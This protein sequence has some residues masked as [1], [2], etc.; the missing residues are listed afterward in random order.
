M[1]NLKKILA[2]VLALVMSLS[3]MATASAASFPDVADDN[4]YKT[5]IDVLNGVKVFQGYNDGAEFRPTGEITRAEVAAIIYRISTGDVTDSQKDIY[6]AWNGA[7]KL[8]DVTTGWYAGYVNFC[9]NAG[10][11]KGYPDGTFKASNK[12]TGYEVLAMILRAVGYGRNGEFSGSNWAITVGSLAQTLGITKN[13]KEDLGSPATRQMV[14]ELLFRSI[15]TETQKYNALYMYEGTGTNLAANLGLE[16]ITGVVTA[17][18]IADLDDTTPLDAGKTRLEAD[19][20]KIYTLNVA[21]TATDIGETRH[22]YVKDGTEVLTTLA[23]TGTN[24]INDNPGQ[25]TTLSKVIKDMGVRLTDETEYYINFGDSEQYTCERR[26]EY[27]VTFD[28]TKELKGTSL[29]AQEWFEAE[30]GV[31]LDKILDDENTLDEVDKT[32]STKVTYTRVIPAE[33]NITE[34]DLAVMR[35][36]FSVADDTAGASLGITGYV[37]AGTNSTNAVERNKDLSEDLSWRTFYNDYINTAAYNI[38][39]SDNGEWFKVIDNNSDGKADYVLLTRF[40][41]TTITDYNSRTGY[42]TT[43]WTSEADEDASDRNTKF[44]DIHKDDIVSDGELSID[45]VILYAKIDG[46][47]YVDAPE[48]V[49]TSIKKFIYK[50]DTITCAD[51]QDRVWSGINREA[52][53]FFEEITDTEMETGR[54]YTMFLD[55]FGYVRLVTDTSKGF[56]LLLDGYYE[57]DRR[58]STMKAT[59]YNDNTGE[60]EDVTVAEDDG[61]SAYY[62]QNEKNTVKFG[63]IDTWEDDH[64]GNRGTWKRLSTFGEYRYGNNPAADYF[65]HYTDYKYEYSKDNFTVQDKFRTNVA[66]SSVEDGEY[67]L[68]DIKDNNSRKTEYNSYE[69]TDV[70]KAKARNLT[71]IV[72]WS[73]ATAIG[74]TIRINTTSATRYYWVS[75]DKDGKTV[76]ETWVGYS[77]APEDFSAVNGYAITSTVTSVDEQAANYEIAQVVVFEGAISEDVPKAMIPYAYAANKRYQGLGWDGE[78]YSDESKVQNSSA[79]AGNLLNS[80]FDYDTGKQVTENFGKYGIWAGYVVTSR[81]T[82]PDYYQFSRSQ[83]LARMTGVEEAPAADYTSGDLDKAYRVIDKKT[84]SLG[85]YT[86]D[87]ADLKLGEKV[88][89]FVDDKDNV[90]L[91]INVSESGNDTIAAELQSLWSDIVLDY[92]RYQAVTV[93]QMFAGAEIG[94]FQVGLDKGVAKFNFTAGSTKFDLLG[95]NWS[96]SVNDVNCPADCVKEI[97]NNNTLRVTGLKGGDEITI[98]YTKDAGKLVDGNNGPIVLTNNG[99]NDSD[100][101]V[102]TNF[103]L[104][105]KDKNPTLKAV[106]NDDGELE[107]GEEASLYFNKLKSRTMGTITINGKVVPADEITLVASKHGAEKATYEKFKIDFTMPKDDEKA[108]EI[109]FGAGS[110]KEDKPVAPDVTVGSDGAATAKPT[111][112]AIKDAIAG[113]DTSVVITVEQ[114]EDKAEIKSTTVELSTEIVKA[115]VDAE[116]PL[117]VEAPQG[118]VTLPTSAISA[119]VDGKKVESVEVVVAEATTTA[120][121]SED[122]VVVDVTVKV[123]GTGAEL[124]E[125]TDKITITLPYTGAE[126][127]VDVYFVNSGNTLGEVAKGVAVKNGTVTFTVDHLTVFAVTEAGASEEPTPDDTELTE[128]KAYAKASLAGYVEWAKKNVSLESEWFN[129]EGELKDNSNTE[130]WKDANYAAKEDAT[131]C[132]ELTNPALICD[133]NLEAGIAEIEKMIDAAETVDD[134]KEIIWANNKDEDGNPVSGFVDLSWDSTA[135]NSDFCKKFGY[136][137]SLKAYIDQQIQLMLVEAAILKKNQSAD[138]SAAKLDTLPT[139]NVTDENRATHYLAAAIRGLYAC[140]EST[141]GGSGAE[142]TPAE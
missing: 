7:G 25:G 84:G 50:N 33:K 18:E 52:A 45:D 105:E 55:H 60:I 122:A 95:Y 78:G 6:T 77:N 5:A 22:A 83:N 64:N 26:L 73:S 68:S 93:K 23:D 113:A 140:V 97:V 121:V 124:S 80:V 114:P 101:P 9:S 70:S 69:L 40:V 107:A 137:G 47:Y 85:G 110:K 109:V 30:Y 36:I 135:T 94:S 79:N 125:L 139:E 104:R 38:D 51:D 141:E 41:M 21:S 131:W 82:N 57:T 39:G 115:V 66:M 90:E 96:G 103:E 3:L 53:A 106:N 8:S 72:D 62:F 27:N 14:A 118:T 134:V 56:V 48:T 86:T 142:N 116:L 44:L 4:A 17:N 35:G 29:N 42:Y 59:V 88:I 67:Y 65:G 87:T 128:A 119:A 111:V 117:T 34:D 76:V 81:E 58:D 11:I 61:E 1:R 2:L 31:D 132:D 91:V 112:D 71:G 130:G 99:G 127:K 12:V 20:G 46:K 120:E 63:Y 100:D 75:S 108:V 92:G 37:F 133:L 54:N 123:N 74:D 43:E 129:N 49:N 13:V 19:N 98:E 16:E 10:Y 138:F 28:N 15:F 126:E 32:N 136:T 24:K 102:Y 89:Y